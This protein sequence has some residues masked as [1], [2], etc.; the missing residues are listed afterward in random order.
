MKNKFKLG[1]ERGRACLESERNNDKS[2]VP[3]ALSHS[4]IIQGWQIW[5][6]LK[7]VWL[8]VLPRQILHKK[9]GSK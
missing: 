4:G 7:E 6:M 2:I 3:V 8:F 5:S 1:K 9:S